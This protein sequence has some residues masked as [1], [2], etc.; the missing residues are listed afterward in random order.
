ME[1]FTAGVP[2]DW[3]INDTRRVYITGQQGRV[4]T[5]NW[6]VHL[7]DGAILHQDIPVES[8]C[9]HRLSFFARG[10][11]SQVGVCARVIY[12]DAQEQ[13]TLGL[14]IQVRKQD[15]G[16]SNRIFTHYEGIS[17]IAPEGTVKARIEFT[18]CADG[19]QGMDLDNVSFS[20]V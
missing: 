17:S 19:E 1:R 13:P 2:N 14:L 20:V 16:T 9:F 7:M 3:L 6:A 12:L 10:E 4:H 11:G 15:M 8:G 5:G 18:V